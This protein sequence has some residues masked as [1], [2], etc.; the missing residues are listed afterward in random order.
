MI[1]TN[2]PRALYGRCI[3]IK[4]W[5]LKADE[6]VEEVAGDDEEFETL[7]RK[8]TRWAADNALTLAQAKPLF[9]AG[10]T[11][12]KSKPNWK[13]L[14]AIAEL[15]GGNW[16]KQAREAAER[17]SRTNRKPSLGVQ[18][19]A[20]MRKLFSTRPEIISAE[21]VKVLTSDLDSVWGEYRGKGAITQRELAALLDPYD[22][23]PM[24]LHPTKRKDV[25]RRGYQAAQF[26]D[27]F[28]RF[29]PPDPNIR[30]RRKKP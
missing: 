11:S 19:L 6:Q 18:L 17:L 5:P 14:L 8:L 10:L 15:A 2:L 12:K 27:A 9:P 20:E 25:S 1:G 29:L 22:I 4:L 26:A 7:R 16:P 13:L 28:A 30:T 24:I 21:L 23:H 3:L